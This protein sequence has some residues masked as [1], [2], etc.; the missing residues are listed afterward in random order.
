MG[1]LWCQSAQNIGLSIYHKHK[2][3][4]KCTV[5]SQSMPV[6]DRRTD[7]RTNIMTIVR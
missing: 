6:P 1:M 7:R 5:W 3:A 4:L 2:S